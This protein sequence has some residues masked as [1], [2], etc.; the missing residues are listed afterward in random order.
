MIVNFICESPERTQ[1]L[2]QAL[3]SLLRPG[4]VVLLTG[5]LGAGKTQLTKGVARALGVERPI[6]SPTFNLVYEYRDALGGRVLLRHFDLYRLEAAEEL[7]DIDYFGL[8]EDEAVSVVEWGDKFAQAMPLAY[9]LV[10]LEFV[11]E[12]TRVLRCEACG[13]RGLELLEALAAVEGAVVL[14]DAA[15]ADE[16]GAVVEGAADGC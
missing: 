7:D 14:E 13:P 16:A 9:L 11:D 2:G 4:D 12:A 10:A 5:E 8:L 6:T 15:A 3:G 1:Q